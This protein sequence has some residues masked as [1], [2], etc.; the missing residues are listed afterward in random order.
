MMRQLPGRNVLFQFFLVVLFPFHAWAFFI[1]LYEL[2][3]YLM[4][5]KVGEIAGILSYV[6]SFA[7]LESLLVAA[8]LVGLA[9][10]LPVKW[11]LDHFL[12]QGVVWVTISA[13]WLVLLNFWLWKQL[14][15]ALFSDGGDKLAWMVLGAPL[16]AWVLSY[17]AAMVGAWFALRRFAW[18]K[19]TLLEFAE[20]ITVL[21]AIFL[22]LDVI[23]LILVGLRNLVS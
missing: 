8:F 7:L 18:V 21:S 23:S 22:A 4:Q 5:L 3:A 9:M 1:F 16:A 20:R 19:R 13:I 15:A 12:A 10:V 2:P 6:F 11:F 14:L 17:L